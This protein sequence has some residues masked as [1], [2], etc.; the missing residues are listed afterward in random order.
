MK[1]IIFVAGVHGAGKGTL[2][3]TVCSILEASTFS[4]SSLIKQ[5]SS[6][7]EDGKAVSS[8]DRNQEALILALEDLPNEK[9]LLDGHFCLISSQGGVFELPYDVFDAIDAKAVILVTCDEKTIRQRLSSRDG[10]V[11]SLKVITELQNKER[12]RA[13]DYCQKNNLP[14]YEFYSGGD[15]TELLNW[16]TSENFSLKKHS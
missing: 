10:N 11:L 3:N 2:C 12:I 8:V 7:V 15:D 9:I 16:L 4:C 13:L 14:L 6:Y 1:E 5:Y